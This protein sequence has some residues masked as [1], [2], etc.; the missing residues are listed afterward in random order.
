MSTINH[1]IILFIEPADFH[2]H[3]ERLSKI[4][5]LFVNRFAIEECMNHEIL[6]IHHLENPYLARLFSGWSSPEEGLD[7]VD[8]GII[9]RTLTAIN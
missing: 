9:A 7:L 5:T 4:G 2:S 8:V 3:S 1:K 6:K